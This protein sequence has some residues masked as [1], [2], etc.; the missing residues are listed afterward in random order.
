MKSYVEAIGTSQVWVGMIEGMN[1]RADPPIL[2]A[3]HDLPP[4]Y[5]V[6]T[7]ISPAR[8]TANPTRATV[9]IGLPVRLYVW[10]SDR[11]FVCLPVCR[12]SAVRHDHWSQQVHLR[13]ST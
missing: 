9:H 1:S 7:F 4:R 3:Y 8:V 5:R 6:V 11:W 12:L 10:L 13:Y 2:I